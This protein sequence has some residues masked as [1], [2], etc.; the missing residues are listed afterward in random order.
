MKFSSGI[1][2]VAGAVAASLLL[3]TA[4]PAQADPVTTPY[5]RDINTIAEQTTAY[6]ENNHLI[7][8]KDALQR[9]AATAEATIADI[10]DGGNTL[11]LGKGHFLRHGDKL[12]IICESGATVTNTPLQALLGNTV[13]DLNVIV[14]EGGR[15]ATFFPVS[16]PVH[17]TNAYALQK[18]DKGGMIGYGTR[19]R[20]FYNA[21]GKYLNRIEVENYSA[22]I[23]SS[24]Y[25]GYIGTKCGWAIGFLSA[26]L[27]ATNMNLFA[28]LVPSPIA[29]T[30]IYLSVIP[31]AIA[32]YHAVGIPASALGKVAGS[33]LSTIAIGFLSSNPETRDLALQALSAALGLVFLWWLPPSATANK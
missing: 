22:V 24:A 19:Q 10:R 9:K 16:K 33:H 18:D 27:V 26:A 30:L 3:V 15:A 5:T 7:P 25:G 29:K 2:A 8:D 11:V 14:K 20:D 13:V 6:V 23:V 4:H 12:A 31:V 21:W 28:K 17:S 32:V 1:K